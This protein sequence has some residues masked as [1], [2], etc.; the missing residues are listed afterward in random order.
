MKTLPILLSCLLLSGIFFLAGCQTTET[1][2]MK[3]GSTVI[4][5]QY[6][7]DIVTHFQ[8]Y[9]PKGATNQT[10]ITSTKHVCKDCGEVMVYKKGGTTMF[11]C[12]KCAPE[13]VSCASCT[14]AK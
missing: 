6:C 4:K 9:S 11:K 13:G 10:T 5:C 7:Y 2:A 3:G 8:S 14:P 1:R 12:P